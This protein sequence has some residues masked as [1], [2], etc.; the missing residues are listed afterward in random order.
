MAITVN[1]VDITARGA[2]KLAT[3][4]LTMWEIDSNGVS[5]YQPQKGD[6]SY[7]TRTDLGYFWLFI[8][9][10]ENTKLHAKAVSELIKSMDS[11]VQTLTGATVGAVKPASSATFVDLSVKGMKRKMVYIKEG[12]KSAA[13]GVDTKDLFAYHNM[14][15]KGTTPAETMD[16]I[17]GTYQPEPKKKTT[18]VVGETIPAKNG[19]AAY[20]VVSTGQ[21]HAFAIKVVKD[22]HGSPT[23]FALRGYTLPLG[24]TCVT[25]DSVPFLKK[26]DGNDYASVHVAV[27]GVSDIIQVLGA[28]SALTNSTLYKQELLKAVDNA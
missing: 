20:T 13:E 8:K 15:M 14:L 28:A 18:L 27:D 12:D 1:N 10:V 23:K 25:G 11:K 7:I 24:E 19:D 3:D 21:Y 9:G 26:K 6:F 4:Y 22:S 16:T 5:I 17:I 2:T